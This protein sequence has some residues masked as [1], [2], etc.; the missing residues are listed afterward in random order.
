MKYLAIIV[1][2]LLLLA[3]IGGGV[4]WANMPTAKLTLSAVRRIGKNF[5]NPGE[6]MAVG[7]WPAWEFTITNTSF[8]VPE[9]QQPWPDWEFAI[10]NTGRASARWE[11]Y[12]QFKDA[13][14]GWIAPYALSV[15]SSVGDLPAGGSA[16]LQAR[17]PPDPGTNWT[18]S[19]RY[20]PA[21]TAVETRL[22]A[23]LKPVPKLRNLLPNSGD[24]W[25]ACTWHTRTNVTA[26]H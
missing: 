22:D 20:W 4:L 7:A 13:G 19:V 23:W 25:S 14:Q 17:V 1:L 3:A 26:A 18:I 8:D 10:T 6:S 16:V 2:G 15:G 12:L 9:P 21:K 24:H 5:P 11:A